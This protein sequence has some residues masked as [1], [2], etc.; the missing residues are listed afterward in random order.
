MPSLRLGSPSPQRLWIT[1]PFPVDNISDLGIT[2]GL[3]NDRE[4][5]T[6]SNRHPVP[7]SSIQYTPSPPTARPE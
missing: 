2:E 6:I 5:L 4:P 7:L 3:H 1:P